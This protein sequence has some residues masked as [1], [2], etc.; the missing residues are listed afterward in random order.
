MPTEEKR[1][2][3]RIRKSLL[4][5]FKDTE[6]KT[7]TIYISNINQEGVC[8]LS[9]VVFQIGDLIEASLKL[10]SRPN[11]WHDCRLKVLESK[12]VTKYP[13][14]F[15]SGF[16]TR[17]K[18]DFIS[19]RTATFLKDYCD[20]AVR[21]NEAFERIYQK[22]IGVWEK[23]S[24][25]RGSIRVNK[26]IVIMYSELSEAADVDWDVTAIRNISTGGAVFTAKREYKR[27]T[28][29]QLLIKIPLKPFDWIPFT[30]KVV[31]SRELHNIDNF[32]VGGTYLTRI[33]FFAVP[34]ENRELLEEYIEWFVSFANKKENQGL[35]L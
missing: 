32:A 18:F 10:P 27:D 21:Q 26:M 6:R 12:D 13:G 7:H 31:E 30:G 14:A 19:E 15:V 9:P 16:R 35:L 2:S 22:R 28:H 23:G 3:I 5:R 24:E 20:F 34:M 17:A 25:K 11:E 4:F 1:K 33:E 8:F 29:L